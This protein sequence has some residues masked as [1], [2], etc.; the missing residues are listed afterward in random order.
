MPAKRRSAGGPRGSERSEEAWDEFE[1]E[2]NAGRGGRSR[3]WG[4]PGAMP[5]N[6]PDER[7]MITAKRKIMKRLA[8]LRRT[9]LRHNKANL[10]VLR[11]ARADGRERC[12]REAAEGGVGAWNAR[13]P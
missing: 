1:A 3:G 10:V 12:C 13:P 8:E 7:A 6:V 5:E 9:R 11:G 2:G 4:Y